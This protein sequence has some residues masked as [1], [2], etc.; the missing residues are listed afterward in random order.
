MAHTII[1]FSDVTG[2]ADRTVW[3]KSRWSVKPTTHL[4][5]LSTLRM[6]GALHS[7]PLYMSLACCTAWERT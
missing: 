6:S 7:R 3:G 2:E 1:L 4:H 5:R